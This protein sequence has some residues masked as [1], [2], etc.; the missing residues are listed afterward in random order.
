MGRGEERA[1]V[2]GGGRKG[3]RGREEGLQHG[4]VGGIIVHGVLLLKVGW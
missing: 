2:K 4:N 3:S 1:R